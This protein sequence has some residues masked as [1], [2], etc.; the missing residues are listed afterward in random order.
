MIASRASLSL[1]VAIVMTSLMVNTNAAPV[2]DDNV[3]SD[4]TMCC[5]KTPCFIGCPV[6]GIPRFCC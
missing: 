4:A 1:F 2:G 3:L 6:G 5:D